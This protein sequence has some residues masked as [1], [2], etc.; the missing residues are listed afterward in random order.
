MSTVSRTAAPGRPTLLLLHG[1]GG[2]EDDLVPLA[3]LLGEGLGYLAP[4]GPDPEGPGFAWFRHHRVGV[5]VVESLDTRL[6]GT[7]EWLEGAAPP[8]GVVAVGFSNGGMMAGALAAARPDLVRAAGLLSSA[9]PLP[10]H[11]MALG[12]LRGTPVFIAAGDADPVHPLPVLQAGREAY[13]AAGARVTAR[14]YPGVGHTVTL[15]EARDLAEWLRRA[16]VAR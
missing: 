12:G 5:P 10:A 15:D 8:E 3:D 6:A 9:Y 1:R 11:V 2:R 4:R 7:A 16:V 14:L 13:E